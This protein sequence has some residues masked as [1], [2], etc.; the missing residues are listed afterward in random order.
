MSKRQQRM[1]YNN[2]QASR[3]GL[4]AGLNWVAAGTLAFGA[5]SFVVPPV[6]AAALI[7]TATALALNAN[8]LG[9]TAAIRKLAAKDEHYL[10]SGMGGHGMGTKMRGIKRISRAISCTLGGAGMTAMAL[11]LASP[12]A[13]IA[14]AVFAADAVLGTAAVALGSLGAKDKIVGHMLQKEENI[15]AR[16]TTNFIKATA[17]KCLFG[18]KKKVWDIEDYI[19]K[20]PSLVPYN[21]IRPLLDKSD[22][23]FAQNA[24]LQ[25]A[26]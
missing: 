24:P 21:A 7:G 1:I 5:V 23:F 18:F 22:K 6:A 20:L 13:P 16:F 11:T 14:A 9:R 4:H 15:H 3:A 25:L 19:S 8:R 26:I 12:A 10:G 17:Q 2:G